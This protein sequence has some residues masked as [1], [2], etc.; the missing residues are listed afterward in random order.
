MA[1]TG[2]NDPPQ[3]TAS[4]GYALY[5]PNM[6][7][8]NGSTLTGGQYEYRVGFNIAGK[9][10]PS[11]YVDETALLISRRSGAGVIN[12][13][14]RYQL[15]KKLQVYDSTD[16]NNTVVM[17]PNGEL[18]LGPAALGTVA[19]QVWNG[20]PNGPNDRVTVVMPAN[21]ASANGIF[22]IVS[23][24]TIAVKGAGTWNG[25]ISVRNTPTGDTYTTFTPFTNKTTDDEIQI[26]VGSFTSC[27]VLVHAYRID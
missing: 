24:N 7:A 9:S 20:S 15:P 17:D 16:V 11:I 27:S 26:S 6:V 3:Y 8:A 2:S 23:S 25:Y 21:T 13:S 10:A 4:L 19:V 14:I 18:R 22:A 5:G 1:V 12:G